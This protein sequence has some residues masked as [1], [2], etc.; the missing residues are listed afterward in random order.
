MTTTLVDDLRTARSRGVRPEAPDAYLRGADLRDAY[1]RGA[2]LRDADLRGADLRDAYL[3]DADLCGANLCG[4]NLC[5]ANLRGAYLRGADLCGAD[6]RGAY[7]RGANLR[8]A[9][10]RD[11][12]LR[13]ADWRGADWRGLH[14]DGLPS[15]QVTLTP[16]PE[17]WDLTI[18]CW[19]H[20]TLA[21]LAALIAGEITPPEA[22]GPEIERR[23]PS[24]VAVLALCEAHAGMHPDVIEALAAKWGQAS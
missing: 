22:R 10:L 4:A 1:L 3:R 18:G 6:L 17:G 9:D 13:G 15:G 19:Q 11:A 16:T 24:W 7:L 20:K 5:G 2:D 12:D 21:D 8:D 23:R 14:I